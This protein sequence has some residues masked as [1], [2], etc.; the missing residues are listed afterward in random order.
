MRT[1]FLD[2][3]GVLQN[4]INEILLALISKV[5]NPTF[6]SQFHPISLCNV[7]FKIITKTMMNCLKWL[8]QEVVS[9]YHILLVPGRQI[10]NNIIV[11]EEVLH[12]VR[13][14]KGKN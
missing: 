11:F 7:T 3:S 9:P 10:S 8:I 13:T 1:L 12:S 6:V 5:T 14:K 4:G 2:R